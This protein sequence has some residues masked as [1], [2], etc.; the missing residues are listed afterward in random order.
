M[1][2]FVGSWHELER[3]NVDMKFKVLIKYGDSAGNVYGPEE[4]II[5]LKAL[6]GIPYIGR[7]D[8]PG[9][10]KRIADSLQEIQRGVSGISSK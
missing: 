6:G 8:I 1:R 4:I 2:E 10:L 5:D 3:E 7:P 9:E